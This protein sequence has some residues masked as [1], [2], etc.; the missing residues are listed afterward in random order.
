MGRASRAAVLRQCDL[1]VEPGALLFLS[2]QLESYLISILQAANL[3]ALNVGRMW[4]SC[5][6]LSTCRSIRRET[7]F[8]D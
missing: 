7:F 5:C 6:D 1:A 2:T 4:I 8:F 3:A